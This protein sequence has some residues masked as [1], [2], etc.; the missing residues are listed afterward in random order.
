MEQYQQIYED[1]IYDIKSMTEKLKEIQNRF[2]IVNKRIIDELRDSKIDKVVLRGGELIMK[3][4]ITKSNIVKKD[5]ED[6]IS[7][8]DL[9]GQDIVETIW[10]NRVYKEIESVK[11]TEFNLKD[12]KS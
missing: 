7:S 10:K 1:L 9:M 3:T 2:R 5:I 4:H 11:Y 6:I 12:L 8:Y